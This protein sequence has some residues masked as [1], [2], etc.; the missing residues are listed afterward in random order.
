MLKGRVV[1]DS[2]DGRSRTTGHSNGETM[3]EGKEWATNVS[4]N[5]RKISMLALPAWCAQRT[6]QKHR[7]NQG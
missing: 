3:A 4:H 7:G 1:E 2:F 6:L 5:S